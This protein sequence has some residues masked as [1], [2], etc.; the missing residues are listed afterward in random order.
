MEELVRHYCVGE[1][2]FGL[3]LSAP[4]SFMEY[5]APVRERIRSAAEGIMAPVLPTRAG[6]DVPPRTFVRSREELPGSLSRFSIDLS[7]YEPFRTSDD[8]DELFRL[9][10]VP[11]APLDDTG[12]ETLITDVNVD[13]PSYSI[14]SRGED[15]VFR[16]RAPDGSAAAMLSIPV[17]MKVGTFIPAS[18]QGAPLSGKAIGFYLNMALMVMYTYNASSLGA[19]LVHASVVSHGWGAHLFLGKSGTG[20]STHSRLWLEN[21]GGSALLNDDNPVLRFSGRDLIVYGTPWSGKTPCYCNTSRKVRS[22]VNLSQAPRNEIHPVKGIP[23]YSF[24]L[25]SVSA[26]RWNRKI[27]D[28]LTSVISAIAMEVPCYRMDC[29]PDADAALTCCRA[30]EGNEPTNP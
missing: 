4:Y 6:D 1:V 5:S 20:K 30:V 26:V 15:T 8:A 25:S 29:L 16:F 23:A 3:E 28:T 27:M 7:Q 11:A 2:V 21:I 24:L 18:R 13:L 14:S 12:G 17:D 10:L 22:I 19:L 9:R